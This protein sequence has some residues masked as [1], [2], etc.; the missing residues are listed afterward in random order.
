VQ[1]DWGNANPK[2]PSIDP[3]AQVDTYVIE[4]PAYKR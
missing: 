1:S 4:L 3:N 2:N